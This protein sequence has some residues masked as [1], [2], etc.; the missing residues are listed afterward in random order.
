LPYRL[1][2]LRESGVQ[3]KIRQYYLPS[4]QPDT[5][6]STIVVGLVTVAPI[7]LLLAAG[8]VIGLILLMIEKFV[9]TYLFRTWSVRFFLWSRNKEY[10]MSGHDHRLLELRFRWHAFWYYSLKN[11]LLVSFIVFL[12]NSCCL[13]LS[14]AS[15]RQWMYLCSNGQFFVTLHD[16]FSFYSVI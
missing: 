8:N 14:L 16:Y 11:I 13:F 9:R 10:R 4:T 12:C 5:E 1:A 7:W 6:P 15:A 2:Q 3:F